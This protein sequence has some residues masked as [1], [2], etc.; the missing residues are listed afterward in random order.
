MFETFRTV[1]TFETFGTFEPFE[2]FGRLEKFEKFEALKKLGEF[3]R[4]AL[5]CSCVAPAAEKARGWKISSCNRFTGVHPV[6]AKAP[7]PVV[8][9]FVILSSDL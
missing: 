3:E 9:F 5:R 7:F 8:I 2:A 6:H 1:E 4:L